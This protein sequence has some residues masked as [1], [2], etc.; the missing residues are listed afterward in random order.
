MN[1]SSFDVQQRRTFLYREHGYNRVGGFEFQLVTPSGRRQSARPTLKEG[2]SKPE[3]V[4][5]G[6]RAEYRQEA[7]LDE[8]LEFS[9][10]GTYVLTIRFTGNAELA[11]RSDPDARKMQ[12]IRIQVLPR[13]EAR[14][15]WTCARLVARA[16]QCCTEDS[17]AAID[18]LGYV[19]DPVAV[20]Y[21][22]ALL[23]EARTSNYFDVLVQIGGADARLALQRLTM[24]RTDW[25]ASNA[26][27]ALQRIK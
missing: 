11:G 5:V 20:P 16:R 7:A 15:A 9:E 8:W 26:L 12:T 22:E 18:E 21:L 17:G 19:R 3:T 6:P 2:G 1:L 27:A 10:T 24:N 23:A 13:D 4:S 25:V 14:L